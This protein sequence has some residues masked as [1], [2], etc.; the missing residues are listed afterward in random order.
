MSYKELYEYCQTLSPEVSR[1]QLKNKVLELSGLDQIRTIKTTLD[2]SKCRG[3]YLSASNTDH[4]IVQQV[5]HHVIVLARDMNRCWERLVYAKELMH[6]FDTDEIATDS[7]DAFEK[8]LT[9][10]TLQSSERSK[11]T[12]SEILCLWMALSV[13]CPEN[14]RLHLKSDRE[15]GRLDD[16]TIALQLRI[17]QQ[18][19]PHLFSE[20]YITTIRSLV[21]Y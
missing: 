19:I 3:F 5:G 14:H 10:L 18:Y 7:G 13:Y 1:T 11:Q 20:R 8:V 16:Y 4:R 9:E 17:P 2:T 12:T 6:V 15:A 21:A